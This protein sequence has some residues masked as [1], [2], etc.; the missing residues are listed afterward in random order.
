MVPPRRQILHNTLKLSDLLLM[1][2]SFILATANY[3]QNGRV[4]FVE[5]LSIRVKVQN[6]VLFLGFLAFMVL[7]LFGIRPVP[8][9]APC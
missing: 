4:S 9:E 7:H 1:V 6:A 8:F 5:S 2:F 3:Y